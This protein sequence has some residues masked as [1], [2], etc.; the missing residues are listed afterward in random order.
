MH[1]LMVSDFYPPFIGGAERQAQLLS[2]QLAL[3]GHSVSVATVW[4][5]GLPAQQNEDG[6][7]VYRLKGLTTQAP[8]F[9][10]DP[11][12]RFH[13]PFPDPGIVWGLRR[14]IAHVQPD[15]VHAAGWIAYSS[16][17]A[18][19]GKRI[20]LLISVRDYGY[21]C[22]IR[23]LLRHDQ[24][25]DGPAPFKCLECASASYGVAKALAAIISVFGGRLLLTRKMSAVHSVSSFVQETIRRDLLASRS[26]TLIAKGTARLVVIPSFLGD[27]SDDPVAQDYLEQLPDQ[28]F[29][30]FVGALQP[31]KGL[32]LVLASYQQLESP[33]PLVLIGSVWPETPRTFPPGVIVLRNVP[34]SAVMVA[35]ERCLF[36][37]IPSVWP[38]PSAGVIREAMSKGKAVIATAVGGST[39]MV[40][41]GETGLLILP[42]DAHA[43]TEAMRQLINDVEQSERLGRA[44]RERARLYTAEAVVPQFEQLYQQ[45]VNDEPRRSSEKLASSVGR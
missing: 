18:L 25:C 35:W 37:V 33:P 3:K 16:V 2:R 28:P 43:L 40:I 10:T 13:P 6:V 21:T 30:L 39:D 19:L 23:T 20:P 31:H 15:V 4:H 44:G 36:G 34:H 14:L 22:A 42:N 17:A 1:I 8:W 38:E 5:T 29:I 27:S 41:N 26:K 32:G 11:K 24:I 45:I 12:R 7:Q 9:S